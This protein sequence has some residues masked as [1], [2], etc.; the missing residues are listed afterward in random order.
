MQRRA[1]YLLLC[2]LAVVGLSACGD[3]ASSSDSPDRQSTSSIPA[4]PSSDADPNAAAVPDALAF[5][6]PGVGGG[7]I[8]LAAYAGK[9][10][11]LWFWAPT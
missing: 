8:D 11:L 5:S 6:A 3:S 2:T 4:T 1:G 9:P 10:V 7:T